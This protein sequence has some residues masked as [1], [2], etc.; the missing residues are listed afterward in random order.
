MTFYPDFD[1][2]ESETE[3]SI[4]SNLR[5]EFNG[6]WY[7]LHF[8]K[9]LYLLPVATEEQRKEARLKAIKMFVAEVYQTIIL[10]NFYQIVTTE[11]ITQGWIGDT[12]GDEKKRLLG[13]IQ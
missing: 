13:G 7:R 10:G 2:F 3:I 8:W 12:K 4:T 5:K 11:G 6:K 9:R 1:I